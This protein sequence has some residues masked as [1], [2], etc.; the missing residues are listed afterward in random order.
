MLQ[1]SLLLA[2]ALSLLRELSPWIS[3]GRVRPLC[4]RLSRRRLCQPLGAFRRFIRSLRSLSFRQLLLRLLFMR[5]LRLCFWALRLPQLTR[6]GLR[7]PLQLCRSRPSLRLQLTPPLQLC[8]SRPL[9]L[10]RLSQPLLRLCL[11][12]LLRLLSL[13]QRR[14]RRI[15]PLRQLPPP[16]RLWLSV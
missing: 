14:R 3:T 4:L 8:R 15:R 12:Q 9:L 1:I 7:L 6:W 11:S 16:L 13:S 10:L 2:Q 5:Q